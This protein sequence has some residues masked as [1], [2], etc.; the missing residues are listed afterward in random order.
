MFIMPSGG[1]VVV[2]LLLV[3]ILKLSH[4]SIVDESTEMVSHY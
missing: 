2:V 4:P 1:N 3:E